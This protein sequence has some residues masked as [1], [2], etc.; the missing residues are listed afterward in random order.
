MVMFPPQ[1]L[2]RGATLRSMSIACTRTSKQHTLL[3]APFVIAGL[4]CGGDVCI[5][6]EWPLWPFSHTCPHS[7]RRDRHGRRAG[8]RRSTS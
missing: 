1:D 2:P 4:A 8:G 6:A 3:A 7:A 5:I